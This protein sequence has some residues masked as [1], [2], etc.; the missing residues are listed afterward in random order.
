MNGLA[1][2]R[3]YEDDTHSPRD[4]VGIA[5]AIRSGLRSPLAV[6]ADHLTRLATWN[7]RIRAVVA[8]RADDAV[9][10]AARLA[11]MVSEGQV[12]GP[13]AGVPFTVKDVIATRDLPTT[14]GS[15]LLAR[16][17]TNEDATAVR[18][19]RKA[20]AILVGKTNCPEFAL[21]IHTDNALYGQTRNPLGPFT[22]GGSSGGEAAAIAAG[23]SA[24]GLGTD[25]GGSAR[26][27]AQCTGLVGLR[28]TVGRVP[29]TGQLP[30]LSER[31][32][33]T[34]DL[35]TLRG[36]AQVIG[37][38]GTCVADV[39][40]VLAVLAGPDG[41]DPQATPVPLGRSDA[42][43]LDRVELRW[44]FRVAGVAATRDIEDALDWAVG[45]LAR[46]GV[47][48]SRGLPGALNQA[49]ELY[50]RLRAADPM[51]EITELTRGR[52][53]LLGEGT[54][55]L[56]GAREAVEE[57]DLVRLWA[58]RDRLC[59]ELGEWLRGDRLLALPVSVR[60]PFD[61]AGN[62]PPAFASAFDVLVP[63]RVVSLFG[64]PAISVPAGR[65]ATGVPVSVQLVAPPYREDLLFRAGRWIEQSQGGGP[66]GPA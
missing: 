62:R 63:S 58:T 52:E 11:R 39:E 30:T 1:P 43:R 34:P 12:V 48:V 57:A 42:V 54:Q 65:T 13:L 3:S 18:R 23:I 35:R 15:R 46:A 6:V 38:I 61:P 20:G 32:P 24:V 31:E 47:L 37:P 51:T 16:H 49:A 5:Q 14:C 33:Y 4:A 25:F 53:S 59:W 64:L 9:E 17:Q 7:P 45:D 8:D 29:S 40:A 36:R 50:S 21:G 44:D 27:P 19:L 28:P 55:A 26:W 22:A 2:A 56:L 41:A 60:P 10:E 66:C